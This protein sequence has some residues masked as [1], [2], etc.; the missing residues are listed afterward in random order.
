MT[1]LMDSPYTVH[2]VGQTFHIPTLAM[3]SSLQS[4]LIWSKAL[5]RFG[6]YFTNRQILKANSNA[7]LQ[8]CVA[9]S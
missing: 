7:S 9:D 6:E 4:D 2:L 5:F 8:I 3:D 1:L